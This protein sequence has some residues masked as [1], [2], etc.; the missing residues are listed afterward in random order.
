MYNLA[1]RLKPE[2]LA[3]ITC[4]LYMEMLE[5][6]FTSVGEFH[7]LHRLVSGKGHARLDPLASASVISESAK[8]TGIH[9]C[10]LPV[11]YQ[12]GGVKQ[13]ATSK[14]KPFLHEKLEDFLSLLQDL[15]KAH[16]DQSLGVAI[17]SLRAVSPDE[18]RN[19]L[20]WIADNKM[21]IHIHIAEQSAEVLDCQKY[22]GKRPVEFLLENFKVNDRWT[23]VHATHVERQEL[24]EIAKKQANVCLCPI[25]EANLGDGI[26]P[27]VD[28]LAE[29]G[30]ICIGSDS[31]ILI[32]PFE[33]MRLLE[34]SQR[35]QHQKRIL[36]NGKGSNSAGLG[37]AQEIY[38]TGNLSL[39]VNSAAIRPGMRADFLVLN[40]HEFEYLMTHENTLWDFLIFSQPRDL[41]DQVYV[42]GK[43]IVSAGKHHLHDEIKE[44]YL[45]TMS[46]IFQENFLA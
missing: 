38:R 3:N 28:F 5:A 18:I 6:G 42:G 36:C 43:R 11:L 8:V 46:R 13:K 41:I 20:S 31:N 27:A 35:Y 34:Y 1:T 12:Q 44:R 4:F 17:H 9:L 33:E 37:I 7:Y 19:L 2:D 30:R 10:L 15:S 32:N 24:H 29:N 45:K 16:A 23:L 21:P 39:R 14:Q 22:L 26:F 25:T 40:T